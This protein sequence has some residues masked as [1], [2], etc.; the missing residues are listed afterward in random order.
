M[1]VF[2]DER[3]KKLFATGRHINLWCVMDS[4][5]WFGKTVLV[6]GA[7]GF[8]GGWLVRRLLK[9]GACVVALVRT[10][11]SQSQFFM[12]FM[13]AHVLVE[14]GS[15]DDQNVVERIFERHSID[16]FFPC[17]P[18]TESPECHRLCRSN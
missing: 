4:K 10:R 2:K 18:G 12:E 6:A 13:D 16:F 11:K 1:A 5:F 15:V 9:Y 14:W 3:R 7:T 17:L 8:L